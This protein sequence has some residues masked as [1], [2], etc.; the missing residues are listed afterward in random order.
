MLNQNEYCRN[1]GI[2]GELPGVKYEDPQGSLVRH[3]AALSEEIGKLIVEI[4]YLTAENQRLQGELDAL[5][6]ALE[7]DGK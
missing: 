2:G 1:K 3:W 4:A 5:N 6:S 7:D